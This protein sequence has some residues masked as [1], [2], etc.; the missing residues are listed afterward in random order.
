MQKYKKIFY[1]K[2]FS[3]SHIGRT[4]QNQ[5]EKYKPFQSFYGSSGCT[6]ISHHRRLLHIQEARQFADKRT[7]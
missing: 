5:K 6:R 3:L 7:L 4:F 1:P 2:G